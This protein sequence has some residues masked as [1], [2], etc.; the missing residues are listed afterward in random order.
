MS[1]W[2]NQ[3]FGEGNDFYAQ[4]ILSSITANLFMQLLIVAGQNHAKSNWEI[5]YEVLVVVTC[6]KPAIDAARVAG[7]KV[8]QTNET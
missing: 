6:I 8:Q 4:A 3:F 1:T 7:G 2:I 5:I